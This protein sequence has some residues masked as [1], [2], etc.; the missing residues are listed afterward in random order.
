[1]SKAID[2][3]YF[4]GRPISPIYSVLMRLREKLYHRGI[5]REQSLPVP[6]ISIG[7]LVL[8]GTG[9]TPT[10]QHVAKL[11]SKHGYHPAI[12]SRGYKGKAKEAV[13]IVSDG[14]N[15]L[16]SPAL[17]GDEPYM[18]AKSLP[19]IPV[20]TGTR[21]IFP[22]RHAIEHFQ[23]DVII[24]DDAFQHLIVKRDIDIV[25]FDSTTLAGNSR[26]FPGGSLREPVS[27]LKRCQAFLLT[28][29]LES[30]KK[31]TKRF[32]NLLQQRFPNR[33]VFISA[34]NSYKLLG[35]YGKYP[36]NISP[37]IFSGFCGIANPLRFEKSL[38]TIGVQLADFQVL[39]DH[40]PYTQALVSNLCKNAVECGAD[41]LVT[42]EKDFVKLQ[43]F[44][45]NLPL[46]VLQVQHEME[47]SFD[48]FLLD[49]LKKLSK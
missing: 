12:I 13:N 27:A 34:L 39:K 17:A 38:S 29:Q 30:N 14:E 33:P 3:F 28:G 18:L 44:N 2:L 48:L 5:F 31:R 40:T 10:V 35:P 9:K 45:L 32:S 15:I 7:N 20:L 1:M 22:C 8:G 6:V 46:Y 47:Q 23:T 24:L 19:Q 43:N 26:V 11:L 36:E 42:T 21:R 25:L 37:E 41:S 16:L 49:N 4:F